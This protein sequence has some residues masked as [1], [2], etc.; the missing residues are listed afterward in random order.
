MLGMLCRWYV[1][2]VTCYA[3]GGT[4]PSIRIV[5]LPLAVHILL[6]IVNYVLRRSKAVNLMHAF[7]GKGF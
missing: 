1:V 7:E 4:A 5:D 6:L 2:S 3:V